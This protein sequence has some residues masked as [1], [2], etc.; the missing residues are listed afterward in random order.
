MLARNSDLYFEVSASSAAFSSSARRACSTSR[1]LALD[2]GVLLGQQLGLGA[3]FLVGLLQLALARL[4][5]HRELLGLR[6]QAFG[7]HGGLDGVEDRA[8]AL[9]QQ[10]EEG[11]RAG[12]EGLQRG[13]FD[14]RLGLAFEQYWQHDD[15]DLPGGA[16][17]R[18]D[19]DEIRRHV[20]QK[21]AL[22]FDRALPDQAL[23][24][25]AIVR[26]KLSRRRAA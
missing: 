20:I 23:G 2:L 22:F 15:A 7:A 17:T 6:E 16:Q 11:Q 18:G 9:R 13:E 8:D 5:F 14:Y 12:I 26:M 21:D 19:L 4:Q 25:G 24:P 10:V 3:Q 1:V